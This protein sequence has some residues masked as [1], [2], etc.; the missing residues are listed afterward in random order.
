MNSNQLLKCATY[1][2]VL[3]VQ[4]LLFPIAAT[5]QSTAF[6]ISPIVK[7]G[8]PVSD[9]GR[10][11]DCDDC[12]GRVIGLHAFNNR[13]DAAISA[14][15]VSG[16]CFTNRFLITGGQSIRLADF[17]HTTEF[18]K[19]TLLA[20]ANV[21]DAG[22]TALN[23]GVTIDNRIVDML[24][25]Y[26][27][28]QISKIVQEFDASPVGGIFNGCGFGQPAINN[29]A[30][31]AF[32]ACGEKD[33]FFFG[34]GVFKYSGGQITKLVVNN[35]PSPIGGTLAPNFIPAQEV[36]LN[37]RGDVLFQAGVILDPSVQE[38]YGLFLKTQEAVK[39]IE[40]D[41]DAMPSGGKVTLNTFGF[42]DLNRRGDVVFAVGLTGGQTDSGIFL[43]WLT[44]LARS[45]CRAKRH[46][47]VVTSPRFQTIASHCRE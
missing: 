4:M 45:C 1:P 29:N 20:T 13:G 6:T 2:L 28:G 10:F 3:A 11:F 22:Q 23:A 43:Y 24:L 35:D 33:G 8:D 15:V 40:V 31:V 7:R 18:G 5:A 12:E 27:G 38:K 25:L 14:E 17:C 44:I 36:Q 39:A 46:P 21:N 34:D 42:G 37:D 32:F 19:L 30:E 47:L 9:G 26:S 41:G 16:T